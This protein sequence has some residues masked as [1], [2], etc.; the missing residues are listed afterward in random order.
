M[1]TATVERAY[2]QTPG[3]PRPLGWNAQHTQLTVSTGLKPVWSDWANADRPG[4]DSDLA[5]TY[6]VGG[7]ASDKAGNP[8]GVPFSTTFYLRRHVE[9]QLSLCLN[10]SGTA[11]AA[12]FEPA[13]P[14]PSAACVTAS[15]A[16]S[17]SLAAGDLDGKEVVAI[18]S[19]SLAFLP[20]DASVESAK[21]SFAFDTP[22]GNPHRLHGT[23]EL[24]EAPFGLELARAFD[25]VVEREI[26]ALALPEVTYPHIVNKDVAKTVITQLASGAKASSPLAQFRARFSQP[27]VDMNGTPDYARL[28]APADSPKLTVTYTCAACP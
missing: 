7:R 8:M 5:V 12:S 3:D 25:A 21:V 26:G 20:L 4:K 23:L 13:A 11:N 1:N 19:Y 27:S 15:A 18:M 14:N 2:V 24:E 10:L 16:V 17:A 22:V 6:E 28:A 9:Q